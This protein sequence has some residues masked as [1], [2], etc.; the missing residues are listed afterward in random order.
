[1]GYS[2]ATPAKSGKAKTEMLGFMSEYF[3]PAH[4]FIPEVLASYDPSS[5]GLLTEDQ[6][7]YDSGPSKMGFNYST[8]TGPEGEYLFY[9]CKWMA[10]KVGRKRRFKKYGLP[11]TSVPYYVYDGYEAIPVLPRSQ[12]A[13]VLAHKAVQFT[14]DL[15]MDFDTRTARLVNRNV[16]IDP[17]WFDAR[18]KR[19]YGPALEEEA[20]H[21]ALLR[22][23]LQRLD[24]LWEER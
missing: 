19:L 14:D 16:E 6:L 11:D 13:D 17:N 21:H 10:L 3:R 18:K 4:E 12:W 24:N 9:I 7:A 22:E 20:M 2:I 5:S 8:S 15:G 1:M 23:E